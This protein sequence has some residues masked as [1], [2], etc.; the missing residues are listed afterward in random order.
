M[1]A[2]LETAGLV[3]GTPD[4][5]D[6]RRTILS[7]TETCRTWVAEGRAARQDWL[8]RA[9]EAQLSPQEQDEVGRVVDLL[10]RLVND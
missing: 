6:G 7:L 3:S 1:I 9:L 5:A 2:A 4:V 10:G 8:A